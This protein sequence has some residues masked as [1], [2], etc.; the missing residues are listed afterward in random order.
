MKFLVRVLD[1]DVDN[2]EVLNTIVGV[3]ELQSYPLCKEMALSSTASRSTALMNR[4]KK[5]TRQSLGEGIVVL[6][7]VLPISVEGQEHSVV[8]LFDNFLRDHLVSGIYYEWVRFLCDNH[9][10]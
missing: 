2:S 6:S 9:S 3:L 1:S 10:A 7:A 4:S 5:T 8:Y